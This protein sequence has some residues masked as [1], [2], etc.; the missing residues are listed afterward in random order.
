MVICNKCGVELDEGM[1]A[2]P[3]CQT[4]IGGDGEDNDLTYRVRTDDIDENKRK[5]LLKRVLWQVTSVLL[6]SG[7]VA[8]LTINLSIQGSITW[9]IYPVCICLMVFCYASLIALGHTG[10]IFQ[11]LGGW[12]MSVIVLIVIKWY[13]GLTWPLQLALPI[14]CSVNAIGVMFI[15]IVT[16]LKTRGLNVLAIALI[17]ISVLCLAIEGI[18]SNYFS[19]AIK[20]QWSVIVA[21]CLLP[22]TAAVFFMFLRTKHNPD[23]QKIFHN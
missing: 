23:L 6:L 20:L 16:N 18:V 15:L 5:H 9:S 13:S 19:N 11:L 2:C 17:S 3:L 22:V 4:P 10:I 12:F 1:S 21:A 14:L 7:I 8:T